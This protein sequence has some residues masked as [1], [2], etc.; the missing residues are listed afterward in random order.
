VY[1]SKL[2]VE[3]CTNSRGHARFDSSAP[4]IDRLSNLGRTEVA[5]V[6]FDRR[7]WHFIMIYSQ[8]MITLLNGV[9]TPLLAGL[10]NNKNTND[11]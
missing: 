1:K 5:A 9:N 4:S 3:R 10:K 11:V 2:Y 7:P 6:C 8:A